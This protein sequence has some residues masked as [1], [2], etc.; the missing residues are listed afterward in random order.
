MCLYS[1][2]TNRVN[3]ERRRRTEEDGTVTKTRTAQ[4]YGALAICQAW[5]EVLPS[6]R[7][8]V[9]LDTPFT[10]KEAE[11]Q[12]GHRTG[13]GRAGDCTRDKPREQV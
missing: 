6:P 9:L 11:A 4:S 12:K 7:D 1:G 10:D 5:L 2:Q 8:G 13:R 3:K